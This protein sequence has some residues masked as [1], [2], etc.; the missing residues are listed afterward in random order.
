MAPGTKI[1]RQNAYKVWT[2]TIEPFL[3]EKAFLF[4]TK[5]SIDSSTSRGDFYN[6]FYFLA[7]FYTFLFWWLE[8]SWTT[9]RCKF[10]ESINFLCI[11]SQTY[12]VLIEWRIYWLIRLIFTTPCEEMLNFSSSM[13]MTF[14]SIIC[15]PG[16]P[17]TS[18]FT[19]SFT[20]PASNW[21]WT[22]GAAFGKIG[23]TTFYHPF[24]KTE[25]KRVSQTWN[26]DIH[27]QTKK[28][29]KRNDRW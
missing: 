14:F 9:R 5:Q 4:R 3:S 19:H 26:L 11:N 7:P 17:F 8:F 21:T 22:L 24:W 12:W 6:L 15:G 25:K 13:L 2:L 18:S 29:E 27:T 16:S 23:C 10:V 28:E 20:L 1:D